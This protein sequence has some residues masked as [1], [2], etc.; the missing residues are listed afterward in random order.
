MSMYTHRSGLYSV[1]VGAR[2]TY[3]TFIHTHAHTH[4]HT[5][6]HT[7]THTHAHTHLYTD[8]PTQAYY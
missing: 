2:A 6:A 1:G 7:H 5:H 8:M 3:I 4:T